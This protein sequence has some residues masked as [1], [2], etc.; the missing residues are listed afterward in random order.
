MSRPNNEPPLHPLPWL[1]S[2]YQELSDE[3][4]LAILDFF[5]ELT[6]AFENRYFAQLHRSNRKAEK[7]PNKRRGGA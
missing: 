4:A 2:P 6:T 7:Q 1:Y 5:Y 3:Q